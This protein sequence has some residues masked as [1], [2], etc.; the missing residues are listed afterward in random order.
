MTRAEVRKEW[1]AR[2]SAF[3]ASGQSVA[4][5]CAAN[6]EKPHLLWAWL[7]RFR[8]TDVAVPV[9]SKWISLE[10]DDPGSNSSR[11]VLHVRVGNAV[12]EIQPGFNPVLLA[13]VVRTLAG[14]C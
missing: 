3:K 13:E 9:P 2:V 14:Q 11:N 5:W 6:D 4:A 7:R 8:S 1:E 12:I 10:M